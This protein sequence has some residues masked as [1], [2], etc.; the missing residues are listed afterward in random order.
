[1]PALLLL[2]GACGSPPQNTPQPP[3]A[4][5]LLPG[6]APSSVPSHSLLPEPTGLPLVPTQAAPTLAPEPELNQSSH[7][8]GSCLLINLPL[9]GGNQPALLD[10]RSGELSL[11]PLPEGYALPQLA[12]A[13]SPRSLLL[14]ST[15]LQDPGFAL[16]DLAS[17]HVTTEVRQSPPNTQDYAALFQALSKEITNDLITKG[18]GPWA[19]EGGMRESLRKAWLDPD[20]SVLY[21]ADTAEDG[22]T[23]LNRYNFRDSS[24][25]ALESEPLYVE[26]FSPSPNGE[27]FLLRKGVNPAFSSPTLTRFYILDQ[28]KQLTALDLPVVPANAYWSANWEADGS[29]SFAA[30]DTLR[31][32]YMRLLRYEPTSASLETRYSKPYHAWLPVGEQ[33]AFLYLGQDKSALS[34][35]SEGHAERV[36][37]IPEQCQRLYPGDADASLYLRCQDG[38]MPWQ[39]LNTAGELQPSATGPRI[40]PQT[41]PT[42]WTLIETREGDQSKLLLRKDNRQFELETVNLRQSFWQPD[43]EVWIFL[44][45]TGLWRVDLETE[46]VSK[47]LGNLAYDYPR[48]EAYWI[49][50]PPD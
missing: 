42:G 21:F 20:G 10:P 30:Y 22:Y 28:G 35:V 32:H 2:V 8:T 6:P 44:S 23:H 50:Y 40:Q 33:L 9:S 39:V 29:L 47:L 7:C 43:G 48:L 18:L 13:L 46:A 34:L 27:F 14:T 16:Y 38:A 26:S 49:K 17:R 37:Y 12:S 25:E 3:P 36:Y 31:L 41:S 15:K 19:L 45:Q 1:M 11:L 24:R 5:T 4:E